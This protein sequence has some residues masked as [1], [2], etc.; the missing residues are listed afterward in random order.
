[1]PK[2]EI[3][4]ELEENHQAMTRLIDEQVFNV[5]T[6][7]LFL[8]RYANVYLKMEDLIKSRDNW[9]KKYEDLKNANN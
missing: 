1:M 7:K 3:L 9:R 4:I 2:S 5:G 8:S 6:S